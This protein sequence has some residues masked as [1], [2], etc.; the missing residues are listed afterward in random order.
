MI[1]PVGEYILVEAIEE[2]QTASGLT[3]QT[4][5]K[6]RPQKGKIIAL[7]EGNRKENGDVIPFRVKVNEVILFKK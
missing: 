4:S 1:R 7:G 5:G 2:T 3:F 6:E